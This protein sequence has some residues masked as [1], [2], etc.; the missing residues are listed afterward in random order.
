MF[1]RIVK[2]SFEESN[3]QLF[4]ENFKENKEKIRNFKG[5]QLLELYQDKND[6]TIFFTYSYW[7]TEADLE[8]YR[9]SEL[10]KAVWA[11]TKVLFNN[12]P[13]AWSVDKVE[14]PPCPR[15]GNY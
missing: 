12:K 15:R 7:E 9:N 14:F 1:V 8:A 11:K 4:L 2:M 3:I 10:F 6:S 13:E 5:C